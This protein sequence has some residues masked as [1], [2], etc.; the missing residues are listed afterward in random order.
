MDRAHASAER[1]RGARPRPARPR[2]GRAAGVRAGRGT[3][4]PRVH[5]RAPRRLLRRT[6][7]PAR[8][9]ARRR[10]PGADV[11]E[12]P[13]R[14]RPV[15]GQ[16]RRVPARAVPRS[17]P[18]R[19][20]G[21]GGSRVRGRE[22]PA[23]APPGSVVLPDARPGGRAGAPDAGG[24]RRPRRRRAR[25][26]RGAPRRLDLDLRHARGPVLRLHRGRGDASELPHVPQPRGRTRP[27]RTGRSRSSAGPTS[28]GTPRDATTRAD[29]RT[30]RCDYH[31]SHERAHRRPVGDRVALG[32][33]EQARARDDRGRERLDLPAP[34]SAAAR[35]GGGRPRR[36]HLGRMPGE[37]RRRRRAGS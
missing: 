25:T 17:R 8:A 31:R 29:V 12:Q 21:P 7:P 1:R 34:G 35:P 28:T 24:A 9:G 23:R 36:E 6:R 19:R 2:P 18:A 3:A 30:A 14:R 5:A 13:R 33:R 16:R 11:G 27:R 22:G 26:H 15:R 37:R 10:L 32:A 20:G 4:L